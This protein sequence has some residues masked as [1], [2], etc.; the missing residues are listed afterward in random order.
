MK[1]IYIILISIALPALAVFLVFFSGDIINKV[2]EKPRREQHPEY[3]RLFDEAMAIVS[4]VHKVTEQKTDYFKYRY[5]LIYE[6][7]KDGECT[8]EYFQDYLDHLNEE[9]IEFA[10]WFEANQREANRLF[11]AADLYAKEHN[12]MW[13]IL[14]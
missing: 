3:F 5:T 6:G 11:K 13:G 9:Y 4:E 7:L 14:Y 12:L 1:D 8:I 10:T 2:F